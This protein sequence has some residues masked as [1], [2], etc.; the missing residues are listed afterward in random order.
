VVALTAY[1][2]R[3]DR[4]RALDAGTDA[5][6]AKPVVVSEFYALLRRLLPQGPGGQG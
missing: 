1:A 2:R 5:Y 3:A 6:L 4:K